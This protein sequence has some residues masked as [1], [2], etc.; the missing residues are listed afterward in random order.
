MQPAWLGA[1]LCYSP[2]KNVYARYTNANIFSFVI[3]LGSKGGFCAWLRCTASPSAGL[4]PCTTSCSSACT[5]S[6]S[7]MCGCTKGHT[8]LNVQ[9]LSLIRCT[10]QGHA[11]SPSL[12]ANLGDVCEPT[13][14]F[15][16]CSLSLSNLSSLSL[17]LC[18]LSLS[19]P[20]V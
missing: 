14:T 11:N 10:C 13:E 17:R 16:L 9:R 3:C 1:S 19:N 5:W 12:I 2:F 8:L 18:S 15:R 20:T 6:P 4:R 7:Q